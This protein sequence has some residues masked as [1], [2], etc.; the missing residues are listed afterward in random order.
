MVHAHDRGLAAFDVG[1]IPRR[2]GHFHHLEP[3]QRLIDF[4]RFRNQF[5]ERLAV[6]PVSD[7][8]VFPSLEPVRTLHECRSGYGRCVLLKN[9]FFLHRPLTFNSSC[10]G[11]VPIQKIGRDR[12]LTIITDALRI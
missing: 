4:E 10:V 12:R 1:A 3:N 11:T 2:V 7:V 5:D 9:I 8:Q 6:G